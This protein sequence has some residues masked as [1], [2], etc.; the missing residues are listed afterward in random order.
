MKHVLVTAVA[1]LVSSVCNA[2]TKTWDGKYDTQNIEVTVVYFVP[3][4][5]RPLTDWRDRVDY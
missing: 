2:G 5:R 4:G 1:L 3:A